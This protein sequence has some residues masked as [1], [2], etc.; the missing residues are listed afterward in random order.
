[1]RG[2]G[3]PISPLDI[4]ETPIISRTSSPN[5]KYSEALNNSVTVKAEP[6]GQSE[7]VIIDPAAKI[8]QN[9]QQGGY[10]N[11]SKGVGKDLTPP[12]G[13]WAWQGVLNWLVE[14]LAAPGWE[15]RHGA[16][17]A[18]RDLL[19]HQ[20]SACGTVRGVTQELN[21]LRGQQCL[22]HVGQALLRTLILD[23]FGDFVGDQVVAPVREAAA[24]ALG[25]V[26]RLMS[27]TSVSTVHS[28]LMDM[29]AQPWSNY[30]DGK[31]KG[32]AWEVRHAGLLGLMYEVAVRPDI[33][34][35]VEDIKPQIDQDRVVKMEE[36]V[37]E[38]LLQ[39]VINAAMLG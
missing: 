31:R 28:Y 5:H 36:D 37:P 4:A 1:M 25:S 8:A 39:R 20:G 35:E 6:G 27:R 3:A 38:N 22:L 15:S 21:I 32:Y 16:A 23:R 7:T 11:A 14:Q 26:L 17:L 29:I 13:V 24:Q 9:M 18:L 12:P 33:V 2:G 10:V 34:T 19:R 30:D